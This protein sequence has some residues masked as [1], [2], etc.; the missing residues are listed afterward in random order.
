MNAQK[1]AEAARAEG[2]DP[3]AARNKAMASHLKRPA[4]CL[5]TQWNGGI[6]PANYAHQG[7]RLIQ[8]SRGACFRAKEPDSIEK[9]LEQ[10][11]HVYRFVRITWEIGKIALSDSVNYRSLVSLCG[12]D[13]IT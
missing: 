12:P 8:A 11:F 3:V 9:Y 10:F 6:A 5:Q 2:S 13:T 1:A 4:A 7:M